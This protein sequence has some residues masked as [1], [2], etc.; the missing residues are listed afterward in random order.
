MT[1][2]GWPDIAREVMQTYSWAWMPFISWIILSKFTIVQLIIAILCQSL[3]HVD[4][5]FSQE[6]AEESEDKNSVD[7]DPVVR[8]QAKFDSLTRNVDKMIVSN[9][10]QSPSSDLL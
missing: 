2:S 1:I 7:V 8:L 6:N 3:K 4:E 9:Q 10:K 5:E